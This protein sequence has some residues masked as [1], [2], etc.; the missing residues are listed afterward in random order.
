V[1]SCTLDTGTKGIAFVIPAEINNQLYNA[2][3]YHKLNSILTVQI[4]SVQKGSDSK[5]SEL[6]TSCNVLKEQS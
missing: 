2:D 4:R 3:F 1:E 6:Y 5:V